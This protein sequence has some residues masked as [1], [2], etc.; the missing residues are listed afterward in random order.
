MGARAERLAF[1]TCAP[2]STRAL[3]GRYGDMALIG[4]TAVAVV[5]LAALAFLAG[6][7]RKAD[8]LIALL[9]DSEQRI[10]TLAASSPVGIFQ[11]DP[12]GHCVYANA[13][14]RELLG[15]VGGG[16]TVDPGWW[17]A[18]PEEDRAAIQET[19]GAA[20]AGKPAVPVRFRIGEGDTPRWLESRAATLR[21]DK[22]AI[23]GCTGTLEDITERERTEAELT[24][25][26]LHDPVTGL[27]NRILFLDRVGMALARTRRLGGEV[28]V[29]FMDLD[30]FKLINDSL[31]HEA[32]D[33]L[34]RTTAR[35]ARRG[36]ARE[37]QRGPA[38]GRRVRPA[39]RGQAP[40]RGRDDR[41]ADRHRGAPRPST[42]IP[43]R[44]WS[45]RA[46]GSRS[47]TGPARRPTSSRRL[48]R[49]CTARRS[50]AR[51]AWRCTT[52]ACARTRC[53]AYRSRAR[54]EPRSTGSI[55]SCSSRPRSAS[56][57]ATSP[58]PRRSCAGATRL[59]AS[60]RRV[61]SSR[62]PRRPG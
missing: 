62:S 18:V 50:A 51:R 20:A 60:C 35:P 33:R 9:E 14:F 4:G 12:A 42:S 6:S 11:L 55:L 16:E 37:R 46:S 43:S 54:C 58:A 8:K 57:T 40:G 7:K 49:P 23:V 5:L 25:Q 31:G 32:G 28:A 21:N 38:R 19:W 26:A 48:T 3:G 53:G 24:H 45:R 34:L 13:R 41:R 44:W 30:R 1:S 39:L 2:G 47:A 10:R 27:P 17:S 36:A 22:G 61:S 56:P 15:L 59:A 52:R 29:L